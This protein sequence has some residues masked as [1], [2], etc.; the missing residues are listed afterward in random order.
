MQEQ[1]MA[2]EEKLGKTVEQK[3]EEFKVPIIPIH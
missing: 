3:E 2:M 1:Y